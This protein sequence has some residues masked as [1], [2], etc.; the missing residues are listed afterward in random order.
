MVMGN[1]KRS[2]CHSSDELRKRASRKGTPI[3]EIIAELKREIAA[4]SS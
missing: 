4:K 3:E 1:C 2:P